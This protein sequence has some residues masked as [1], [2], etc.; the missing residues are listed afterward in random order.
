MGNQNQLAEFDVEVSATGIGRVTINGEDVT[1]RLT[2]V[3]LD[4]AHGG[5]PVLTVWHAGAFGDVKGVGVVRVV[6]QDNGESTAAWLAN[7]DPAE[8]DKAVLE[9][10]GWGESETMAMVLTVLQEWARGS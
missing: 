2:G 10:M 3:R 8:L 9:R 5:T 6:D 1:D 4:S 7:L